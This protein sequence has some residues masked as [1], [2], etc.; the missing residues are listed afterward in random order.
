MVGK[1]EVRKGSVQAIHAFL[2]TFENHP[3][4]T[5]VLLKCKFL[6]DVRSLSLHEIRSFLSPLF[7][8]YP[9]AASRIVLLDQGSVSM[10]GLYS[11]ADV[12][13]YPSLAEGV[14]LPLLEAMSMGLPSIVAPYTA[15]LD[16]ADKNTSVLLKDLGYGPMLDPFYGLT[17]E[18][19]GNAGIVT[20]EQVREGIKEAYEMTSKE[21]LALSGA[22]IEKAKEWTARNRAKDLLAI[23]SS[24]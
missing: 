12:L 2:E 14:G 19:F 13:L 20:V 10:P 1:F 24:I 5:K 6:S 18:T 9:M 15:L 22:S 3:D 7:A 17:P 23:A 4:R 16:Y 11:G 8:R 21:R